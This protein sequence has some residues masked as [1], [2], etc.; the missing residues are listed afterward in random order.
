M[1]DQKKNEHPIM[2][3]PLP[4]LLDR[5]GADAKEAK[6]IAKRTEK[7]MKTKKAKKR[8]AW[9]K[10]K[11]FFVAIGRW[12]KN[13]RC[14][15]GWILFI[16]VLIAL[17]FSLVCCR[18]ERIVVVPGPTPSA[19]PPVTITVVPAPVATPTPVPTPT[20]T[21]KEV[22]PPEVQ[23][24]LKQLQE[25]NSILKERLAES[26]KAQVPVVITQNDI[27]GTITAR[28]ALDLIKLSCPRTSSAGGLRAVEFSTADL[29][30]EDVFRKWLAQ[31]KT[32]NEA[33]DDNW[34][35]I[36]ALQHNLRS[37]PG[38]RDIPINRARMGSQTLVAVVLYDNLE[39]AP[40]LYIF[41]PLNESG[42]QKISPINPNQV[43][44]YVHL[45]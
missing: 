23:A 9:K 26:E 1:T 16:I 17:I 30:T 33:L 18:S 15:L 42:I 14:C 6:N 39:R 37:Q 25:E 41:D 38:G 27:V 28:E 34:D 4:D 44:E 24:Q 2:N 20:P 19:P 12:I 32:E 21:V 35:Y 43:I 22:I 31:D 40:R 3:T 5:V 8:M 7:T 29:V 45:D 11:S 13:H 10:T 36:A